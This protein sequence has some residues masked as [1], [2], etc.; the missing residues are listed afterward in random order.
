MEE[1]LM[2]IEIIKSPKSFVGRVQSD[3]GGRREYASPSFEDVLEQL[4]MDVQEE[5]E[6]QSGYF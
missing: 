4:V 1:P 5:L 3:L 6:G 2:S